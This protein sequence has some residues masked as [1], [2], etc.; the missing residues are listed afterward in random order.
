MLKKWQYNAKSLFENLT[1]RKG[2]LKINMERIVFNIEETSTKNLHGE[3]NFQRVG[4]GHW[5][6]GFRQTK[7]QLR[8][9]SRIFK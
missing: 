2:Q 4:D 7:G 6:N 3:D 9:S 8:A 5:C 1:K